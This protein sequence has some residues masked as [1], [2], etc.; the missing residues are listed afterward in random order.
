MFYDFDSDSLDVQPA[1]QPPRIIPIERKCELG[2]A[3]VHGDHYR[4][5]TNRKSVSVRGTSGRIEG[6]S[7]WTS[8]S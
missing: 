8:M 6:Q 5:R 1:V 2:T 7:S 4:P 3:T